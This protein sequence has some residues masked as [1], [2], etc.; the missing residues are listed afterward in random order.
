MYHPCKPDQIIVVFNS[1]ARYEG[2]FLSD[3]IMTGPNLN[4]KN[5][6][7]VFLH[8]R[9]EPVAVMTGNQT[10]F[11]CFIVQEDNSLF[12]RI[13]WYRNNDVSDEVIDYLMKI[14]VFAKSPFPAVAIYVLRTA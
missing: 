2:F 8:V 5:L 1:N 14:L 11:H 3:V 6:I 7:G 13:W 9:Q 10:M 12:L 4:I